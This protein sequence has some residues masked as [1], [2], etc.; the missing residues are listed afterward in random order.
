FG[1]G[2]A[3]KGGQPSCQSLLQAG[4][5]TP[6]TA[7][8]NNDIPAQFALKNSSEP[9]MLEQQVAAFLEEP[10]FAYKHPLI[11]RRSLNDGERDNLIKIGIIR[12]SYTGALTA[13]R[14]QDVVRLM[15]SHYQGKYVEYDKISRKKK[16]M[17]TGIEQPEYVYVKE[18]LDSMER[19]KQLIQA[20]ASYNAELNR[21]RLCE[22]KTFFDINTMTIQQP[23]PK[24]HVKPPC[25]RPP[26]LIAVSKE[27]LLR[28]IA[29]GPEV[30]PLRTVSNSLSSNCYFANV[31]PPPVKVS[32]QEIL[33]EEEN[34][35]A[36]SSIHGGHSLACVQKG[37]G[38]KLSKSTMNSSRVDSG[39]ECCAFCG[40]RVLANERY[41][42]CFKCGSCGHPQCMEMSDEMYA[43]VKTYD[44]MCMECKP[45]SICSKLDAEDKMLFCDRCDRGYHTFCVGLSGPPEGPWVC[46]AYCLRREGSNSG[47]TLRTDGSSPSPAANGLIYCEDCQMGEMGELFVVVTNGKMLSISNDAEQSCNCAGIRR[48]PREE[49]CIMYCV[50]ACG[51]LPPAI[52]YALQTTTIVI[53]LSRSRVSNLEGDLVSSSHVDGINEDQCPDHANTS[54][55]LKAASRSFELSLSSS[56]SP[57]NLNGDRHL[58]GTA[59]C[60][61]LVTLP[62]EYEHRNFLHDL[63][64][65]PENGCLVVE[66]SEPSTLTSLVK[67]GD[68]IISVNGTPV[69]T[70]DELKTQLQS[71]EAV[72][73]EVVSSALKTV[74]VAAEEVYVKC[75]FDYD[76]SVDQRLEQK[77]SGLPFKVGDILQVNGHL[78]DDWW[79]ARKVDDWAAN[80]LIPSVKLQKSTYT[81]EGGR[82]EKLFHGG[83]SGDASGF[84]QHK[85]ING[86]TLLHRKSTRESEKSTAITSMF[87]EELVQTSPYGRKVIMLIGARGVGRRTIKSHLLHHD[88]D[89][90]ATIV[91]YTSRRPREGEREGREYHFAT[92]HQI[93][94]EIARDKFLE[95]GELNGNLYGTKIDSVRDVIR[96]GQVCVI[97]CNPEALKVLR[98]REF[99]PFV[100]FIEPPPFEEFK[101]IY[102]IHREILTPRKDEELLQICQES[103]AIKQGYRQFFDLILVNRNTEVTFRRLLDTL[104]SLKLRKQ[105]IPSQWQ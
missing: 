44:W 49:I 64:L 5:E 17:L 65:R 91:P 68:S 27:G 104:E 20:T 22:R 82:C 28:N 4:A 54:K 14:V 34:R 99:M 10:D 101:Q 37:R 77:Q 29:S 23:N 74:P 88:P 39:N 59:Y 33:L 31:S 95:Y 63:S 102:A 98:N 56:I 8:V 81:T 50:V 87:Y 7:Q 11:L 41:V 90:F 83:L 79:Q 69:H 93:K 13:L 103:E 105:W 66:K 40:M 60:S 26:L 84:L 30:L 3:N 25:Y 89:H 94:E 86:L 100:V 78:D 96:K 9:F 42:K 21:S 35:M 48:Y 80:G 2:G 67:E 57:R 58:V 46:V 45:C 75:L 36:T 97:D 55:P 1:G 51:R 6:R 16:A 62:R 15:M 71:A 92:H 12:K 38:R 18:R 85:I 73:L 32:E 72:T 70:E 43:T 24:R 61:R 19:R 47:S 76:P 53:R 52:D